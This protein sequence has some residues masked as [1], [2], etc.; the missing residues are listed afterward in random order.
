MSVKVYL[1]KEQNCPN[2][3][4]F[5]DAASSDKE[6]DDRKPIP[7]DVSICYECT[8][9]LTFDENMDLQLLSVDELVDLPN[10]ILYDLTKSRNEINRFKK[11]REQHK[12]REISESLLHDLDQVGESI[13][14]GDN[15][16]IRRINPAELSGNVLEAL[17]DIL[18]AEM[19][20][21]L[22]QAAKEADD[23]FEDITPEA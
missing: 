12:N 5:M 21:G 14:K 4:A 18:P 11:Y 16:E 13:F 15:F 9:Y 17:R 6:A 1:G 10:E 22:E 20:E 2:C 8:A 7:G 19:F 23:E 3:G